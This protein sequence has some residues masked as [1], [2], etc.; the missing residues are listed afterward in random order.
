MGKRETSPTDATAALDGIN[1]PI[2]RSGT[3]PMWLDRNR[4][5]THAL[6][7]AA[8]LAVSATLA[9]RAHAD[10]DLG[11]AANYGI[12]I[13]PGAK[14]YQLNNATVNANVGIGTGL[15]GSVQIANNGFITG[16]LQIVDSSETV[17][18]P[19]NVG[20][21]VL[22]NQSQVTTAINTVVALGT[23]FAGETGSGLVIVGEGQVINAN[24]GTLINGNEV[25]TVA[26]NQ[27]NNDK[28][29]ITIT[30]T[31]SQFVVINVNNSGNESIGGPI[32]L[33]GG[34]TSD[35]VF[36]NFTGSGN[37][38]ST[39]VSPFAAFTVNGTFFVPNMKVNL[40]NIDIEGRLFGGQAGQDFSTVGGFVLDA[41]QL[42]GVPEPS[43]TAL[44]FVMAVAGLGYAR[45]RRGKGNATAA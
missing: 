9:P 36:F 32:S 7:F 39:L 22:F 17:T 43:T 8:A 1:P 11:V 40:N 21:G 13:E 31:A 41:P 44:A 24:S 20:G 10:I 3:K 33:T 30:G 2:S 35:Q 14:S 29:G 28:G 26:G 6:A 5:R 42:P 19:G 12:L 15:T 18:N 45:L 4:N 16:Q 34:I 27:Y 23:T 37:L 25:F 38:G